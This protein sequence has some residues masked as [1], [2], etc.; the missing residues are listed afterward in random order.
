MRFTIAG[1]G[2]LLG[3]ALMSGSPAPATDLTPLKIELL[4]RHLIVAHGAIGPLEGLRF[5]IDTGTIPSIVDR[6]I[7]KKLALDVR[8]GEYIAFGQRARKETAVL[9]EVRLGSL[10]ARAV[11]VGVADLSFLHGVDA[12]VGL[13]VLA[14][15]SFSVDYEGRWLALGPVE[16]RDPSVRLELTPP[17]LTVEVTISG[18]PFRVLVDTGSNRLVLFERRTRGRLP[19]LP[20]RGELLLN[21]LSGSSRLNRVLLPAVGVGG[22][23]QDRVEGFLSDAPLDGYPTGI[24]G[25]LGVR[26]LMSKRADFDFERNRLAFDK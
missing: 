21:H 7:A 13:D 9:P 16:Q 17:F 8:K 26:V 15:S 10:R 18:R 4:D 11:P 23:L 14:R 6:R 3:M 25:V 1:F 22:A 5:L 24:D 12:I 2:G 19:T 20:V